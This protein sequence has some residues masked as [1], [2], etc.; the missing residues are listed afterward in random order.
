MLTE[1]LQTNLIAGGVP[2]GIKCLPGDAGWRTKRINIKTMTIHG[3]KRTSAKGIDMEELP[4]SRIRRRRKP[5]RDDDRSVLCD[6][7]SRD[8]RTGASAIL[9]YSRCTM[10]IDSTAPEEVNA[11]IPLPVGYSRCNLLADDL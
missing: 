8:G 11:L 3:N 5:K 6:G 7:S 1:A 2:A 4:F 9:L 10:P